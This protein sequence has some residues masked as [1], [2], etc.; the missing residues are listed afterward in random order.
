MV[1]NGTLRSINSDLYQEIDLRL[2]PTYVI[3]VAYLARAIV[4]S[5]IEWRSF[6]WMMQIPS[7]QNKL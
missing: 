3:R 5:L 7:E 6:V 2:K 4:G 1:P